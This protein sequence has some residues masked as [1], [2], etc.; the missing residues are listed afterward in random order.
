MRPTIILLGSVSLC[1]R[2]RHTGDSFS[3]RR[4]N[5][6]FRSRLR[7]KHRFFPR[8]HLATGRRSHAFHA[9]HSRHSSH[10]FHS[11]HSS[12][13]THHG[14]L[15]HRCFLGSNRFK[16]RHE[17]GVMEHLNLVLDDF[18]I[19]MIKD[20]LRD[21]PLREVPFRRIVNQTKL[22]I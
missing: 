11:W 5:S 6:L 19:A 13:G 16:L 14:L 1:R 18:I 8:R 17:L 3:A 2:G 10:A 7:K 21:P 4:S 22:C 15:L 9:F 20:V 12:H